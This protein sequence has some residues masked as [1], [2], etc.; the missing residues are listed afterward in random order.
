[1]RKVYTPNLV[2][3]IPNHLKSSMYSIINFMQKNYGAKCVIVGGAVRDMLLDRDVKDLDMEC[4][5]IDEKD[6]HQAMESLKANGVGKSFFVY[7]IGDIDIALPRVEQKIGVGHRAFSVEIAKDEKEAS[8]RRDFTVNALIYD[9]V[10]GYIHDYWGGLDDI[11]SKS[12]RA[13]DK[14]TFIE[15]SLRVLRGMQFSARFG[16]RIDKDTCKLCKDIPLNDLSKS[17][18]FNEFLKMFRGSFAHYGLYALE[19]MDISTKLWGKGLDRSAFLKAA[20]DMARYIKD[21]DIVDDIIRDSYFL[22][23]YLQYSSVSSKEILDAIDAPNRYKRLLLDLPTIPKDIKNS[24]VASL[25]EKEGVSKHP[26]SYHPTIRQKAKELNIWDKPFDIG[27]TPT[28]LLELGFKGKELGDELKR[29]R[30]QKLEELDL[31]P[32]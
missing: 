29:I 20:L 24:F 14:D 9:P 23:I 30:E 12:L 31:Y 16:F 4:Y 3:K 32:Y 5:G 10:S 1:M 27:I 21:S 26:L 11:A 13:V 7:K 8:R 19:S 22:A 25:A 28:K 18:I 2:D 17:R 15:D 6:F